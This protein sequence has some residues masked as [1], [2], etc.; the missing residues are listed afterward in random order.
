MITNRNG[1]G[2]ACTVCAR[3][4]SPQE[5]QAIALEAEKAKPAAKPKTTR[6]RKTTKEAA[7]S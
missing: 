3:S 6:K 7:D 4:I 5:K 1:R 2:D